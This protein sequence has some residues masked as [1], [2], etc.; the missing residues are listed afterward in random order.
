MSRTTRPG[1]RDRSPGARPAAGRGM[2]DLHPR[3]LVPARAQERS[4]MRVRAWHAQL[5]ARSRPR[6]RRR[7]LIAGDAALALALA[8]LAVASPASGDGPRI[9]AAGIALALLQT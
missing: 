8:A 7:L 3:R 6:W 4:L 2:A 1:G 9:G 5:D